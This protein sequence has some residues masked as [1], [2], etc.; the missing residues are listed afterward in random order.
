M[1]A[2]TVSELVAQLVVWQGERFMDPAVWKAILEK[3]SSEV[4]P[5]NLE[6]LQNLTLPE[7]QNL[8]ATVIQQQVNFLVIGGQTKESFG[9]AEVSQAI[10]AATNLAFKPKGEP[11]QKNKEIAAPKMMPTHGQ[12]EQRIPVSTPEESA[13]KQNKG[14]PDILY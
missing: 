7:I 3:I 13:S 2:A 10:E 14:K 6:E 9:L 11:R 4:F 5:E 12:Q 8:K 1:R